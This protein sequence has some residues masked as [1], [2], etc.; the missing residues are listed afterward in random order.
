MESINLFNFHKGQVIKVQQNFIFHN[1]SPIKEKSDN[2]EGLQ[3]L[4]NKSLSI[5]C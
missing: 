1:Y 4:T 5:G 3:R 2:V